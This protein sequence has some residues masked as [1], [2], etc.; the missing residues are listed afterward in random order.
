MNLRTWLGAGAA[1]MGWIM[2]DAQAASTLDVLRE[3]N[4]SLR[5]IV[6]DNGMVCLIKED[7]S[8][9]VVAMQ[10]WVGTG[11]MHEEESLGA[12]LSHY[13]EH[14]IFKGTQKRGPTDIS[15]EIDE[16]GGDINAYTSNDRT[17]FYCD[18]PSRNWTVGIDVLSDAVM[19][20]S[21]P[22]AEWEREKEVILRE[23]AMGYDDPDRV[24][25]KLLWATA[26][27][28]HPFRVPVIGYED[29]FR[30]M[31][32]DNLEAFFHRHYVPDN[33]IVSIVGDINATDVEARL[34]EAFAGFKRRARAPVIVPQEPPQLSPRETRETGPYNIARLQWAYHTVALSDPDSPALDI[35]ANIVGQGRSSRVV[36]DLKEKQKLVYDIDAW[37]YTPKDPG[38]FGLSAAFDPA[39]EAEVVAAIEKQVGSWITGSFTDEEIAKAKRQMLVGELSSLQT[40]SGQAASYAS[41][42]FYAGNPR[43]GEEYLAR[44][45]SVDSAALQAVAKKYLRPENRT[46]VILA[47]A[48]TNEVTTTTAAAAP[49][50]QFHRVTLSNG[51]PLI[52]REDHRLPFVYASVVLGGGL[53]A[54]DASNNGIT[55]L[56]SD[57]LTRGTAKSSADEIARRLENLGATLSP[58][59]GR[60]SFGLTAQSLSADADVLLAMLAD[61]LLHSSFPEDELAKQRDVQLAAIRQQREQPM[62]LAQELL[63]RQLFPSHPYRFTPAGTEE[64]VAALTRDRVKDKFNELLTSG[65]LAISIF[66]DIAVADAQKLAESAFAD[67]PKGPAPSWDHADQEPKLPGRQE[68]REPREQAVLLLGYP[69]IDLRDPR[70][71]AVN[72]LSRALSGLSSDLGIEIREK[73]GLVYYVGAFSMAGTDP[74]FFSLYAGTREDAVK[75]VETL[76]REQVHRIVKDGLRDEEWKRARE[77]LLA[78]ADMSLQN[79]GELAQACAL[80]E[81]YGLGYRYVLDLRDRLQALDSEAIRAAAASLFKD[82]REAIAAILPATTTTKETQ[83]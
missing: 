29:V 41:G 68:A 74:G 66:G 7:R 38:L 24:I 40:A 73:R 62:F 63:R 21:L 79:N 43:F 18:L 5:R 58:F 27:R 9:P 54:E 2:M 75:E 77:Q 25:N 14:M 26:Y 64:S 49:A 50:S 32:R 20:A 45:E 65:N 31:T 19:N 11:A 52:V 16:A 36:A 42:E 6:L 72:V 44:L 70:V 69:G 48:V 33:M 76:M 61:C 30:T 82:D 80:H 83:P 56:M 57:L 13:M 81:L 78:A 60:N 37:S 4:A 47:P 71:D 55:Q 8:A 67:V 23:F 35:L 17:V 34:R 10:I 39:R 3:S 12:G 53:L 22:E 28:V 51:I 1:L 59:A 15:R 46:L